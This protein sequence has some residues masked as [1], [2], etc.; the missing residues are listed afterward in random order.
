[1][2]MASMHRATQFDVRNL[3]GMLNMAAMLTNAKNAQDL[4]KAPVICVHS[5]PWAG[6]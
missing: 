4:L 2:A 6:E 5:P 1:M 3:G